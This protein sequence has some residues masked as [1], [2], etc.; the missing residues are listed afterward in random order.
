MYLEYLVQGPDRSFCARL[1]WQVPLGNED[2][3]G[4]MEYESIYEEHTF[5]KYFLFTNFHRATGP[6]S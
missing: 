6:K 4:Y 5:G 1:T 2:T 3:F